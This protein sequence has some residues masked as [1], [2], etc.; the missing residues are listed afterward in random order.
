MVF[1]SDIMVP[2]CSLISSFL[3]LILCYLTYKESKQQRQRVVYIV[4]C[5]CP[6]TLSTRRDVDSANEP[7]QT[8]LQPQ[9][10]QF[11]IIKCRYI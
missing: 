1:I 6:S 11:Y 5:L 4:L 2:I 8:F 7:T 9:T 10:A 3:S